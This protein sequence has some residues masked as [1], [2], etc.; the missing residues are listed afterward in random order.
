VKVGILAVIIGALMTLLLM[1]TVFAG[2]PAI[3]NSG[4]KTIK[5][6]SANLT[7]TMS[8]TG[9]GNASV[10]IYYGITDGVTNASNWTS[11][12]SLGSLGTGYFG[13]VVTGLTANEVYY[14][15]CFANNSGNTSWASPT[16]SFSTLANTTPAV[17][18]GWVAN[19]THVN[20]TVNANLTDD[21][22]LPCTIWIQ[23]GTTT[24][25]GADSSNET[26]KY[27]VYEFN[28]TLTDLAPHTTYYYRGA[29]TNTNGT[30]YGVI[31][32][33]Y[34]GFVAITPPDSIAVFE[35]EVFRDIQEDGDQMFV[36]RYFINYSD[37]PPYSARNLFLMGIFEDGGYDVGVLRYTGDTWRYGYHIAGVYLLSD[38]ALEWGEDYSVVVMGNPDYWDLVEDSQMDTYVLTGSDYRSDA[39]LCAFLLDQGKELQTETG[40]T[41]IDDSGNLNSYATQI[42]IQ[43]IPGLPAVCPDIFSTAVHTMVVPETNFTRIYEGTLTDQKGTRLTAAL[44]GLG[45]WMGVSG[46][47]VGLGLVLFAYVL[48]GGWIFAGT[49]SS[50]A[51]I[52]LGIPIFFAGSLMGIIPL[53][54]LWIGILIVTVVFGIYFILG[55][56][57]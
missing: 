22:G 43:A 7:G 40:D 31:N 19:T 15:R 11:S 38:N 56:F 20:A 39:G 32:T 33:F 48:L 9:N 36:M 52:I 55:R 57:A 54:V 2:A 10:T 21:G 23:Y 16:A 28:V 14:Y 1:N 42:F 18:T 35:V 25:L 4:A 5:Q 12:T 8:D 29:A 27:E 50:E 30:R 53:T 3:T 6:Y 46:G 44:N 34:T 45:D 47:W 26:G 24:G 13:K 37:E 51:A 17:E 41:Y 49:R